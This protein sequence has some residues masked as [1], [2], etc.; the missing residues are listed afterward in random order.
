[1]LPVSR[2][3]LTVSSSS[4]LSRSCLFIMT[5]SFLSFAMSIMS[6]SSRSSSLERSS[7][8]ITRSAFSM[9]SLE[10]STPIFSTTSSVDLIPAV[11]TSLIGIPSRVRYSSIMSLVVPAMSVTI[12]RF[13]FS[14]PLRREDFPTFGFPMITV[15]SPSLYIFPASKLWIILSISWRCFC[16]L[17]MSSA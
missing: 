4:L 10:R 5:M 3:C 6:M 16:V 2:C 13:S 8:R 9:D 15:L 1:M 7:I 17:S 11:S 14:M 12:A